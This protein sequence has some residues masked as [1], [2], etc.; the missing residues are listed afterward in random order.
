MSLKSKLINAVRH[1]SLSNIWNYATFLMVR[2]LGPK[3]AAKL[4]LMG[5]DWSQIQPNRP[6]VVCIS[7]DYFTKDVKE[8]N[9][10]G[11]FS[12]F[13]I[14]GGYTKFQS[15][16]TPS[17]LRIQTYYQRQLSGHRRATS[18]S[19]A[20]A[21]A[22]LEQISKHGTVS[23][24][25]SANIDYWQDTGFKKMAK[26]LAIPFLSLS[27]EH[28]TIPKS[29]NICRERFQDAEFQFEGS[30]VAVAGP[31]TLDILKSSG[32]CGENQI[33]VTGFPR[34]D[35]WNKV[36]TARPLQKRPYVTLLTYSKGYYA[37]DHFVELLNLFIE[38]ARENTTV[39]QV[40][41]V[42]KTKNLEDQ[43]YV[44]SIIHKDLPEN[45]D[46]S[47][48]KP[49]FKV[50]PKSRLV[51]GFNSLALGEAL[52]ANSEVLVPNWGSCHRPSE[53]L[54]LPPTNSLN[55]KIIHYPNSKEEFQTKMQEA[56]SGVFK[57]I[58]RKTRHEV[59]NQLFYFPATGTISEK[60]EDFILKHIQNPQSHPNL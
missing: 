24:I 44:K 37:D 57:S 31:Q 12:Y 60:V 36:D 6:V 8:L 22:I 40:Q 3:F 59:L 21:R 2:A 43:H 13:E 10:L 23:A 4:T 15:H 29:F 41:F 14:N 42:V 9:R 49:L 38:I 50:L 52:I 28:Y 56:V 47:Y 30:G 5:S 17:S 25:M 33:S 16:W 26:E 46:I 51:I 54:I 48:E 27:R 45:I 55:Q 19:I 53:E 7:R 18:N 20:Y 11:Q 1:P 34:F 32:A 39:K 58:D 35:A